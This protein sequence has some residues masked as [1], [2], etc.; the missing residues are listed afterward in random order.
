MAETDSPEAKLLN[1]LFHDLN[2]S[3]LSYAVMRNYDSLPSSAGSSDLDMLIDPGQEKLVV[4]CIENSIKNADGVI[5]GRVSTAGL[6]KIFA[7][8]KPDNV[9]DEWWGLRLDICI[10]VVYRGSCNLIDKSVWTEQIEDHNGI[11]VLSSDLASVIGVMKELFH[12]GV[13][14]ERY[15]DQASDASC[16]R[17]PEVS[18]ALSPIGEKALARFRKICQENINGAA[19]NLEARRLRR[20]VELKSLVISPLSYVSNKIKYYGSKLLRLLYPPGKMIVFLGT[21]GAGKSTVIEAIKPALMDA[22]HKALS[23]KHFRPSLLPPLGRI[24][25]KNYDSKQTVTDPH[26]AAP[27]GYLLS[28]AR[29]AYYFLDY[30]VGYWLLIRP[31]LSKSPTIV[32]FDRY[33]YDILLDPRRLRINLP[34]WVLRVFVSVIPKP[35][36]IICLHGNPE[37]IAERKKE[38]PVN[39]VERQVNALVAFSENGKNRVL[40]STESTIVETRNHVLNSIKNVC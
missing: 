24:K 7:L 5:I 14:G 25:E 37:V 2:D 4:E 6:L 13:I 36:L 17:W 40:I 15:I 9:D 39:E 22:T 28:F 34:Q 27:S 19:A 11:S 29:L 8:G 35:D 32:I 12:N 1:K 21:D 26:G 30:A 23:V 31:I 18:S 20:V 33:A 3:G 10:G 16:N 38:L